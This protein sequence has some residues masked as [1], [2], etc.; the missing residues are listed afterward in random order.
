[1]WAPGVDVS[2]VPDGLEA[3]LESVHELIPGA[4]VASLHEKLVATVWSWA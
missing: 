1:V 4:P 2:N 3:R